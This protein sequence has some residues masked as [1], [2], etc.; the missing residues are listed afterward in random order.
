M[1]SYLKGVSVALN[2]PLMVVKDIS[3]DNTKADSIAKIAKEQLKKESPS[4]EDFDP[5]D[6]NPFYPKDPGFKKK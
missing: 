4:M 2:K 6:A 5:G 1:A 3:A